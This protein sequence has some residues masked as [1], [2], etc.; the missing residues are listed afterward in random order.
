M[1]ETNAPF[2][3]PYVD[4]EALQKARDPSGNGHDDGEDNME[5]E[6]EAAHL[7]VWLSRHNERPKVVLELPS[8]DR[9]NQDPSRSDA[10]ED[11]SQTKGLTGAERQVTRVG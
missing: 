3:A 6:Y 9:T 11:A 5:K 10:V 4:L 2:L 1:I 7:A 8:L